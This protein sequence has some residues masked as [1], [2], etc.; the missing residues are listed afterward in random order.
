MSTGA[1]PTSGSRCRVQRPKARC[2]QNHMKITDISVR[3]F[4][5]NARHLMRHAERIAVEAGCRGVH[6]DTHDFQAPGF[7]E[8]LGYQRFGQLEHYPDQDIH[9]YFAKRLR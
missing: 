3:D 6:L 7:Y 4:K 1:S 2:W 8:R 9:S 5:E